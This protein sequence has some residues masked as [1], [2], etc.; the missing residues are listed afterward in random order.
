MSAATAAEKTRENLQVFPKSATQETLNC[1]KGALGSLIEL[2]DVAWPNF[3]AT[4]PDEF[5]KWQ[6]E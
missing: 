1:M 4:S 3:S 2:N 6:T 5:G